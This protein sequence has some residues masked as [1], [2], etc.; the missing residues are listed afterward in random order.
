MSGTPVVRGRGRGRGRG[1]PVAQA[2]FGLVEALVALL[3]ICLGL[4]GIAALFGRSLLANRTALARTQA[5]N[6]AADMAERIRGN[7]LAGDAYAAAAGDH[8]CDGA[9]AASCSPR[10]MAAHD[11]LD[12]RARV[13]AALP[14]GVGSVAVAGSGRYTICVAWRETGMAA[15]DAEQSYTVEIVVAER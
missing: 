8:G 6:L 14:D 7:R 2:G 9:G 3:V 12:W 4:L 13:A 15:G 1:K 5:V 10:Q 11:L